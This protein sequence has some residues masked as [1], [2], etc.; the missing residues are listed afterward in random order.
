MAPDDDLDPERPPG[1]PP[2]PGDRTW[3]HP[4]ELGRATAASTGAAGTPAEPLHAATRRTSD[5]TVLAGACLAGVLVV[6]GALMLTRPMPGRDATDL[7]TDR[8]VA[9][10]SV[11]V[12]TS[13]AAPLA[14]AAS[15]VQRA[16]V[17]GLRD[18]PGAAPGRLRVDVT[19]VVDGPGALV[20][21]VDPSGPAAAAGV[22]TGDVI[23]AV[24]GTATADAADLLGALEGTRTGQTVRVGLQRGDRPFDVA[25]TLG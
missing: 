23:V 11:R 16:Q 10:S 20:V 17:H 25:V 22:Q 24:E 5:R 4:S 2:P 8:V 3:R 15:P 13:M 21:T 7:A 14:A 1:G 6:F 18:R 12:A 9:R 19:D